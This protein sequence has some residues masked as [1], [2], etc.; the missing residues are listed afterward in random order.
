MDFFSKASFFLGGRGEGRVVIVV[1]V[2][3]VVVAITNYI[4]VALICC[5]GSFARGVRG[6]R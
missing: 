2:V 5:C 4:L 1:V 3:V 6:G